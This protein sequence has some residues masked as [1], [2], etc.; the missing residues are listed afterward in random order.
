MSG[1]TVNAS[2]VARF[3]RASPPEQPLASIMTGQAGAVL[4]IG[5]ISR[6][7][8]EAH[9]NSVLSAAGVD[10]RLTRPVTCFTTE[11]LLVRFRASE[12]LA[13]DCVLE[14]HTLV[15]MANHAGV[16][17]SVF[18]A[19]LCGRLWNGNSGFACRKAQGN[20]DEYERDHQGRVPSSHFSL[21]FA[22]NDPSLELSCGFEH[23]SGTSRG[24]VTDRKCSKRNLRASKT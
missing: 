18:T 23:R 11:F 8:S 17:S 2:D 16:A 12:C 14:V 5:R 1:V 19:R 4:F 3:V 24:N 9:G 10:M 6:I 13:H 15:R 7:F 20:C 22:K 21:P